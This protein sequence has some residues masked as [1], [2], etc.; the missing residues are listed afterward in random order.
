MGSRP[1]QT[2]FEQLDAHARTLTAGAG[3]TASQPYRHVGDVCVRA[4][5]RRLAALAATLNRP[6]SPMM[7]AKRALE[8]DAGALGAFPFCADEIFAQPGRDNY[9]KECYREERAR[10]EALASEALAACCV[11]PLTERYARLQE[12]DEQFAAVIADRMLRSGAAERFLVALDRAVKREE[13][14]AELE[15]A[16][17]VLRAEAGVLREG[18]EPG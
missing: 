17:A 2:F 5:E 11:T 4:C 18:R 9:S 6:T 7:R 3:A 15:A 13:Q 14:A 12:L 10:Y 1:T 8:E 16:A